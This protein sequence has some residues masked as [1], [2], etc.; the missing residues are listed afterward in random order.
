MNFVEW[1]NDRG[2]VPAEISPPVAPPT[3][4]GKTWWHAT[5]ALGKASPQAV[6]GVTH[7]GSRGAAQ[8]RADVQE[9]IANEHSAVLYGISLPHGLSV[10]PEVYIEN[11][12][13]KEMQAFE[14]RLLASDCDVAF[15]WNKKES[16]GSWTIIVRR[17]RL[18]E[19]PSALG[20]G[21]LWKCSCDWEP[22]DFYNYMKSLTG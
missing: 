7:L 15:T 14:K 3:L 16:A 9:L 17:D 4:E 2:F 18:G 11:C 20:D 21:V 13:Q 8:D 22:G 5:S 12:G 6:K 1:D 19:I 10:L